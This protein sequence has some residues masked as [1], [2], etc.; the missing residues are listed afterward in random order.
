MTDSASNPAAPL[1][2]PL[3]GVR[4]LDFASGAI[5]AIGRQLAELG[6]DVIRIEP[7]G[8]AADRGEG[9]SVAGVSIGFVAANLGKRAIV[10]DLADAAGKAH[11]ERLLTSADLLIESTEPGST[12]AAELDVSGIRRRHPKLVLMSVTPFGLE[13]RFRNWQATDPILHALSGELSRSGLKGRPPLL[14]P[15]TLA[16]D[17]AI[18]QAVFALLLAFYNRLRTGEGDHLDLSL[19][20][21]ASQAL[22]PGYG[23]SGSA[24]MG[25]PASKLP[26]GRENATARYPI[27]ACADGYTRICML[28]PRQWQGMFEWMGRPE[29]F[30]DPAFNSLMNRFRS[31]TLIPAI[32]KLF[33]GKTR[34]ELEAEGQRFGVPTAAVLSPKEAM[35][36][37]QMKARGATRMM[38]LGAGVE[39]PFPDGVM[40]IDGL[41][42]G[43]RGPVPVLES[44]AHFDAQSRLAES[45][46][47]PAA[48]ERPLSGLRVLDLGVIVVGA[49]QSRL[50]GDQGAEVYK[51]ETSA[52]P[53]GSRQTIDGAN[54]SP[55]LASGHR[56]KLGLGLNLRDAQG[57]ALFLELAKT[58]DVVFSNFKPGTMESLGL[59]YEALS[60]VNPGIVVIDSSAFGPTGPWAKRLGY[61][62]LV[63]ASTGLTAQWCYPGDE[64]GYSDAITVYP[65]HVAGRTSAIGALALLI[66][67]LRTGR[68]GRVSISQAEVMLGHMA[69]QAAEAA[70]LSAGQALEGPAQ[71]DAPWGV[72]ACEGEDEWCAVTVRG[73]AD[74]KALC[75][76]IDAP[77]LLADSR[78]ASVAGRIAERERI[79]ASL[80]DWL[81]TRSPYQA[82]ETLQAAGVPAAPML[83]VIELPDYDYFRD[84]G[85]FKLVQHPLLAE[86]FHIESWPVKSL[87]LP[88]PAN[89]PAPL[90]G[91]HSRLIL[92]ERLGMSDETIS[93]L[94]EAKVIEVAAG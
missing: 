60:A 10:L 17:C 21:A 51:V 37:P 44:A 63:R 40:E 52:F 20:D 26:R 89:Q 49:E 33:A 83:R 28:A 93:A 61:G 48:G 88:E 24:A 25:V 56:N 14:P 43:I 50:F 30:A 1:D 19:L 76:V 77:E 8:G 66:R 58:A 82:A 74:F 2:L 71:Q 80:R 87:R 6:A 78:L 38:S 84:R 16:I 15:G 53:D 73:D 23:I 18:P 4:V 36:S 92:R 64:L 69:P 67:R 47:A 70:L 94:V 45:V 22:D 39:A 79:E 32:G 29:E 68:G 46:T 5:G 75:E 54:M 34:A 85:I 3:A 90:I 59:G 35:E 12:A 91:E 86:P 41:R 72:Y 7:P 9:R 42:A 11:F 27:I 65:D 55:S 31:K 81:R 62:P 57:K 13:G